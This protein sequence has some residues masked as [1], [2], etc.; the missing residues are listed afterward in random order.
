MGSTAAFPVVVHEKGDPRYNGV[1]TI[2]TLTI[3]KITV[4]E[5][6]EAVTPSD[7]FMYSILSDSLVK[8]Y[9]GKWE[10]SKEKDLTVVRWSADFQPKFPLIGWL[11]AKVTKRVIHQIIDQIEA[12]DMDG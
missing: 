3:G 5:R 6:L 11:I 9:L 7:F 8:Q 1:G 2:R 4:M 10:F 12:D